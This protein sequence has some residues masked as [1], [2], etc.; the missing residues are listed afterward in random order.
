MSEEQLAATALI[1]ASV[2]LEQFKTLSD[3]S[4]APALGVLLVVSLEKPSDHH[5]VDKPPFLGPRQ[6]DEL[7]PQHRRPHFFTA[8]SRHRFQGSCGS[9]VIA[10]QGVACITSTTA[11]GESFIAATPSVHS[12]R[13]R[14]RVLLGAK[15][16]L[17][18]R[19]LNGRE[20]SA[21]STG[22]AREGSSLTA[23]RRLE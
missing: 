4:Q 12:G 3:F 16:D 20:M 23:A 6:D 22:N 10:E 17:F 14:L 8:G 11:A 13:R 5:L 2:R 9:I 18:A 7:P 15:R 21:T 19:A 1:D